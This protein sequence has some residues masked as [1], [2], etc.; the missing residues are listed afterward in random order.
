MRTTNDAPIIAAEPEHR[1]HPDGRAAAR[2]ASTPP[3]PERCRRGVCQ[4][5]PRAACAEPCR[6]QDR[7]SAA[8]AE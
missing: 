1:C 5:L 8:A 2:P 7:G 3:D 6:T 4:Q